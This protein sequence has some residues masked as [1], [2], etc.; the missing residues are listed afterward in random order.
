MRGAA[1]SGDNEPDSL[2]FHLQAEPA[3]GGGTMDSAD[4]KSTHSVSGA[5]C[6]G[7]QQLDQKRLFSLRDKEISSN[8]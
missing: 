2:F 3:M 4:N 5:R 6:Y 8:Y 1:L 7:E